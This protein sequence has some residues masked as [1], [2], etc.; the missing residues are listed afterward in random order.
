MREANQVIDSG[1]E[2]V[3]VTSC[4]IWSISNPCFQSI[5]KN[6]SRHKCASRSGQKH[7]ANPR[8][9]KPNLPGP[10]WFHPRISTPGLRAFGVV[11]G[12]DGMQQTQGLETVD[13]DLQDT[14]VGGFEWRKVDQEHYL[15]LLWIW[16]DFSHFVL[17]FGWMT[18][19]HIFLSSKC[20]VWYVR[21]S[22]CRRMIQTHM[23]NGC[24]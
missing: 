9:Q 4:Y 11:T 14:M 20:S 16:A 22:F 2:K 13:P 15:K 23:E 19:G 10:S 8:K 12:L 7:F 5:S 21:W 1:S 24:L 3:L 18:L 6:C 17:D